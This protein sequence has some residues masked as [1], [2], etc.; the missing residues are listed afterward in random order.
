MASSC[1]APGLRRCAPPCTRPASCRP[2]VGCGCGADP[3]PEGDAVWR[4]A[5][6]LHRALSGRTLT[7]TDF[8]VPAIATADLAGGTVVETVSRGKHLLTRIDAAAIAGQAW[9]LHT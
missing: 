1:S 4:T 2:P 5:R 6:R 9:T 3:V 8:R 7:R